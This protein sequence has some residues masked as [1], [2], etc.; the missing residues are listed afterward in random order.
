MIQ[1]EESKN[2][3]LP[4]LNRMDIAFRMKEA[5]RIWQQNGTLDDVEL[6]RLVDVAFTGTDIS[7]DGWVSHEE[8]LWAYS[9]HEKIDIAALIQLLNTHRTR[10]LLEM[11]FDVVKPKLR[12]Y[13]K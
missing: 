5:L 11:V 8:F 13:R 10:R 1:V 3:E 2:T 6:S 4:R 9:S 7:D 12:A